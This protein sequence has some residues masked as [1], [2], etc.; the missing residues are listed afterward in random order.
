M[1]AKKKL[2]VD[3]IYIE[4]SEIEETGEYDL[5]GLFIRLGS[6]IDSIGS[7]RVAIDT[8]E[9]LF[10]GFKNEAIRVLSYVGSPA[11]LIRRARWL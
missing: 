1:V 5:E 3:Y 9:V 6:A 7:K 11:N 8:L 4:K 2:V 10:S